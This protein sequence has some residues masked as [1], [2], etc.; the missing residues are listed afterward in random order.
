[1]HV[2]FT[3]CSQEKSPPPSLLGYAI[4]QTP[5]EQQGIPNLH[6]NQTRGQGDGDGDGDGDG[7]GRTEEYEGPEG[8]GE[9]GEA[10][11]RMERSSQATEPNPS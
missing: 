8:A 4:E 7:G 1:M 3:Q 10:T 5:C 11:R 6:F 2:R 9:V